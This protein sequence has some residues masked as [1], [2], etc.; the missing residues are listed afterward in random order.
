MTLNGVIAIILLYFT[1]SFTGLLRNVTVVEDRPLSAEY[2]LPL[3]AITFPLLQ[4]GLSA[5]A[6]FI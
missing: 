6:E 1:D 2:S 5:L 4:L 3:L